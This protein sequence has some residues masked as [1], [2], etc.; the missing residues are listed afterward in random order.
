M[1]HID[2]RT[3]LR[4]AA[5]GAAAGTLAPG[6]ILAGTPARRPAWWPT[7]PIRIRGRVRSDGRG[8]RRAVVSDGLATA[9]TDTDGY[10][11][12]VSD[13][14]RRWVSLTLPA[15]H[16]VPTHETGTA[17]LYRPIADRGD[18]MAVA[19]DLEPRLDDDTRHSFLLLADP[20]TETDWEMGRLH[21][22]T[23]PDVQATI[24]A[25]DRP[26]FGVACGDIMYDN[27]GLY[28]QYERAVAAM[29]VPFFQVVGNHDLD[30]D[31]GSDVASTLT[32]QR[33]FGPGHYSFEMGDVHYVVLD[34]VFWHGAGYI[35]YLT[36]EA[37]TWLASD[38]SHVEPGRTVVVFLHIPVLPG[39][40][41]RRG[42]R[43]P[44]PS[45]SVTNREALYPILEPYDAHV[46]S[47]HTHE[48][49]HP[50]HGGLREH[51]NGAV[52]G[53]W[54][55]GDIC[56]DGTPNGY[57]VYDVRG[58]R[59]SWRYKATGRPAD[60]QLRV[61][62]VGADPEAPDELVANVWFADEDWS[63]VWYE[64]GDRRGLMARRVGFDPLAVALHAGEEKPSHRPWVD[65][66][67]TGHMYYAPA[68]PAA[69]VTVEATDP[70][71]RTFAA[72]PEAVASGD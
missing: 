12:L 34:D 72:R 26:V 20:Q 28:P 5:L 13:T 29:G 27:L 67:P 43:R 69:D 35:G 61:Y 8:L 42:Q 7:D 23:V 58:E 40:Y 22:E 10:F 36:A 14:A 60:H 68:D 49:E 9:A 50:R 59:L 17:R 55:S 52:C 71:G 47:G 44:D 6:R 64:G 33:H 25:M 21:A 38:L 16:R 18:E 70:F 3:F 45:V 62:P 30:F 65:P 63:V 46:L 39:S 24:G 56:Y 66:V 48:S 31:G 15:G 51:V 4:D 1:R 32:F 53:A 41:E 2:R 19:F 57:G 54:W 37:L 11:E